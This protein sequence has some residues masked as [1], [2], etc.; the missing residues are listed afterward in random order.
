MDNIN[1]NFLEQLRNIETKLERQIKLPK[2]SNILFRALIAFSAVFIF[3]SALQP[4]QLFLNHSKY[5]GF[6]IYF[7]LAF[8]AVLVHVSIWFFVIKFFSDENEKKW[9]ALKSLILKCIIAFTI[10]CCFYIIA[11][12]LGFEVDL[13]F[14][15]MWGLI[16]TPSF[17]VAFLL[18]EIYQSPP[19]HT[20]TPFSVEISPTFQLADVHSFCYAIT[21]KKTS[22]LDNT[23]AIINNGIFLHF[24]NEIKLQN[25]TLSNFLAANMQFET[26]VRCHDSYIVNLA[27]VSKFDEEQGILMIGN[28]QIS[29]SKKGGNGIEN[30]AEISKKLRSLML[31]K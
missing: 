18:Y 10:L 19:T 28:S 11:S 23:Q 14:F 21:C 20:S 25:T 17:A 4:K 2:F 8:T 6:S 27:K 7:I 5:S 16:V 31:I 13:A 24:D 1:T 22:S 9:T 26:L 3:L 29:V 15:I 30:I 12:L